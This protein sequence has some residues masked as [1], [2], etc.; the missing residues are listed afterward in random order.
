M[1]RI[2]TYDEAYAFIMKGRNKKD[3]PINHKHCRIHL[4]S[5]YLIEVVLYGTSIIQ[6]YKSS[7]GVQ[8]MSVDSWYDSQTTRRKIEQVTG[9]RTSWFADAPVLANTQYLTVDP[10]DDTDSYV[11]AGDSRYGKDHRFNYIADTQ[12]RIRPDGS[13]VHEKRARERLNKL[14]R[15]LSVKHMNAVV[16]MARRATQKELEQNAVEKAFNDRIN[17]LN[18]ELKKLLDEI[19]YLRSLKDSSEAPDE[20]MLSGVRNRL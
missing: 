10:N 5:E 4:R 17:G 12:T 8:T 3:R 20:N 7:S 13:I 2:R 19:G 1:V 11:W 6:Y 18:E 15:S 9:I 14:A 16:Q